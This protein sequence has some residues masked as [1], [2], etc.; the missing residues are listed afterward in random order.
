LVAAVVCCDRR[1]SLGNLHLSREDGSLLN[2]LTTDGSAI[3][4][5]PVAVGKTMIVVTCA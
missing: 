4:H 1:D 3:S 5:N 2:R